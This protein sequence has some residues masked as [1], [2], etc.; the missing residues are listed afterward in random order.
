MCALF[1]LEQIRPPAAEVIAS[2][3]LTPQ[4]AAALRAAAEQHCAAL[5]PHLPD[6]TAAFD[7]PHHR[8]HLPNVATQARVQHQPRPQP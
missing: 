5:G 7:L 1:L 2:G 6:L 3:H 4:D 8:T